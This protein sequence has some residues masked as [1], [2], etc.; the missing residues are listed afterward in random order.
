MNGHGDDPWAGRTVGADPI[1]SEAQAAA[2]SP[3]IG[4][5]NIREGRP[6]RPERKRVRWAV[7]IIAVLL[8]ALA[9]YRIGTDPSHDTARL[10]GHLLGIG[11]VIAIIFF[12][13]ASVTSRLA[14]RAWLGPLEF[15]LLLAAAALG[16]VAHGG[17]G[18]VGYESGW[19][20]Q[21]PGLAAQTRQH[22]SLW[23]GAVNAGGMPPPRRAL[24]G[25]GDA[26]KV[27]NFMDEAIY[28]NVVDSGRF[29]Q[30]C[31]ARLDA[32][33]RPRELVAGGGFDRARQ[34]LAQCR[35]AAVA[36]RDSIHRRL[37]GLPH[38][39][40]AVDLDP[41][42][43]RDFV[44]GVKAGLAGRTS[45]MD[46]LWNI[47]IDLIDDNLRIVDHLEATRAR[48]R[49]QGGRLVFTRQSDLDKLDTLQAT[50]EGNARKH[51]A[52]RVQIESTAANALNTLGQI[53]PDN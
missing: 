45:D 37:V 32:A 48:W 43:K 52:L 10:I 12:I 29:G 15:G 53:G 17:A 31:K 26:A 18:S 5:L 21:M 30:A 11:L 24:V 34:V 41:R 28:G 51:E 4:R 8:A 2:D 14:A 3:F 20:S 49:P 39:A 1:V 9:G 38:V 50:L 35:V 36:A 33:M 23:E 22:I 46:N 16:A 7:V 27:M 44:E 47:Q 42:V 6:Y 40:E 13:I 25:S 19:R